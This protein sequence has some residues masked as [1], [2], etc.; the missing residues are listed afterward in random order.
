MSNGLYSVYKQRLGNKE[1]DMDVDVFKALLLDSAFYTVNLATHQ[2]LS[3]VN[4]SAIVAASL[5]LAN[6]TFLLGVF[7]TDDF[8]FLSVVGAQS[9][10]LGIYDDTHASDA[11]VAYWDTGI[12]GMPITPNGANI[13]VIVAAGGWFAL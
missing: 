7:N 13:S 6:P 12:T 9:E 11:L 5:G 10:A 1:L 3:D 2:N 4:G 8:A